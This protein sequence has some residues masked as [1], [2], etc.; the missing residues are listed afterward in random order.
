MADEPTKEPLEGLHI[1]EYDS[2]KEIVT[3]QVHRYLLNNPNSIAALQKLMAEI[4]QHGPS[5]S[6]VKIEPRKP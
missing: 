3:I 4:I 5:V 1:T 2:N 6:G